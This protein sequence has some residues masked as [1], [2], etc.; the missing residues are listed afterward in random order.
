MGISEKLGRLPSPTAMLVASTGTLRAVLGTGLFRLLRIRDDAVK[1][2]ARGATSHGI[3]TARAFQV[4]PVM[5]AFAGHAM[6]LSAFVTALL[7]PPLLRW[8]GLVG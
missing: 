5:G 1:G 4:S 8:I 7:L 6:A 3:G 2:F